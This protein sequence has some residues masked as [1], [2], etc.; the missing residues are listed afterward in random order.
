MSINKMRG[1]VFVVC[2]LLR[3]CLVTIQQLL[4]DMPLHDLYF[5]GP[6]LYG[7]GFWGGTAKEEIC[8]TLS[9]GTTAFFWRNN[10]DQCDSVLDMRFNAFKV[11]V[12]FGVYLLCVYRLIHWACFQ[13]FVMRPML[14]RVDGILHLQDQAEAAARSRSRSRARSLTST[15]QHDVLV[16]QPQPQPQPQHDHH[17]WH[18]SFLRS[19]S[20]ARTRGRTASPRP[21]DPEKAT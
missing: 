20:S 14:K 5:N 16:R 10:S 9:P 2:Q 4:I 11:A 17:F 12:K 8:T 21:R 7:Y 13:L 15:H 6:L 1:L 18:K 19:R 3:H